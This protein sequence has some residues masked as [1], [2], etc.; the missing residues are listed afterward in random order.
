[1]VIDLC[2]RVCSRALCYTELL[3]SY[4]CSDSVNYSFNPYT[5]SEYKHMNICTDKLFLGKS[6]VENIL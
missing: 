1:M 3:R 5:C 4:S 6:L 2:M